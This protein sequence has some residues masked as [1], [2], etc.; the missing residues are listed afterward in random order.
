MA[1]HSTSIPIRG[2]QASAHSQAPAD[3]HD[4]ETWAQQATDHLRALNLS[5]TTYP[6]PME[7]GVRGTSI[8]LQIPLDEPA[9][10]SHVLRDPRARPPGA[11]AEDGAKL[12]DKEDREE[13]KQQGIGL[14][15]RRSSIQRDSMKRREALLKGKEG[16][17]RRQ[18]WENDHLLNVPN[19]QPPLPSDWEIRPTY[20]VRHVPYFLAPLWDERA[21]KRPSALN[22]RRAGLRSKDKHPA[23]SISKEAA[24]VQKELRAKMKKARGA[25]NLLMDLEKTVRAFIQK[26]EEKEAELERSG[27]FANDK[28]SDVGSLDEC[29]I[30]SD[31]SDEEIVFVGRDLAMRDLKLEQEREEKKRKMEAEESRRDKLVFEGLVDDH[32]AAFGRWLVHSIG[33]YYGLR[34]WSITVG[35]PARREA[36]VGIADGVAIGRMRESSSRVQLPKPLWVTV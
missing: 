36:Y 10:T 1:I 16:S 2:Q 30:D 34:T 27:A 23:E 15:R 20:P 19:A 5:A 9:H 17:R 31:A 14:V 22:A 8:S 29:A 26:W 21:A 18:R 24:K 25:K 6:P 35:D 4:V 13:Q 28:R 11:S 3:P 32:G 12:G 33:A 7:S